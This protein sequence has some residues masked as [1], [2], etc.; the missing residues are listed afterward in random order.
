MLP[1]RLIVTQR[2]RFDSAHDLLGLLDEV[3][4]LRVG[5]DVELP[6]TL[7]EVREIGNR[8]VPKDFGLAILTAADAFGQMRYEP[9]HLF[10]E[11]GLGKLH[12]F[13]ETRGHTLRLL[14]QSATFGGLNYFVGMLK[15]DKDVFNTFLDARACRAKSKFA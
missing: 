7:E 6:K 4:Q 14:F 15:V 3:I 2:L 1:H 11:R 10:D 9:A 12:R 8:R 5:S 13:I